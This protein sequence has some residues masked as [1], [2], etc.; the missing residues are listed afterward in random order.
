MN[1]QLTAT[2]V[3]LVIAMALFLS[4]RLSLNLAVMLAWLVFRAADSAMNSV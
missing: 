2:L 3:I 1:P 4:E